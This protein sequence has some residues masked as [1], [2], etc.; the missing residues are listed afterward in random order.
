[1]KADLELEVG[2]L[3]RVGEDIH[4]AGSGRN[5]FLKIYAYHLIAMKSAI[6]N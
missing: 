1:M 4:G 2:A 5:A 6:S 3:D